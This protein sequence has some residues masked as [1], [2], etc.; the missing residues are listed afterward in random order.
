MNTI[1]KSLIKSAIIIIVSSVLG[2]LFVWIANLVSPMPSWSG[3]DAFILHYSFIHSVSTLFGFPLLYGFVIF[4]SSVFSLNKREELKINLI[5]AVI[6]TGIYGTLVTFN[7]IANSTYIGQVLNDYKGT[8]AILTM[9]NPKSICWALE[10]F[11][12]GFLGIATYLVAPVFHKQRPIEL[13][14][15]A[16]GAISV[17]GAFITFL[18]LSWVLT[19]VGMFFYISWNVLIIVTMVFVLIK[20]SEFA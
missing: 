12:Y 20:R 18:N 11:G 16:N 15:K 4:I 10:M 17:L 19:P 1:E 13:L 3:V 8:V 9:S 7:Y 14:L 2:P 6:F 5:A